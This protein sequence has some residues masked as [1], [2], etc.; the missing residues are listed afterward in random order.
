[1]HAF[2]QFALIGLGSGGIYAL[3]AQGIVLVYRGSGIVNFA[4]GGFAIVGAFCYYKLLRAHVPSGLAAPGAIGASG[5]LGLLTHAVLI[6]NI[7]QPSPLVRMVAT[8]GLLTALQAGA[9]LVFGSNTTF[10]ASPLPHGSV[11]VL[12][13]IITTHRLY[14]VAISGVLSVVLWAVYR[15]STFGLV[16]S[17]VSENIRSA[18]ALGRQPDAIA[19]INWGLG[20]ALAGAAGI[21]VAPIIGL[22]VGQL[23]LLLVPSLAAALVG[24][25]R[26]FWLTCIGGVAIGIAQSE[27]TYYVSAPGWSTSV[28][29]IVIAAVLVLRG[30]A[31]PVRGHVVDRLPLVGRGSISLSKIAIPAAMGVVAI[32]LLSDLWVL[33][34]TTSIIAAIICLS[35]VVVTGYTGQLS[36]AQ[37]VLAGCGALVAAWTSAKAGLPFLVD[38][39]IGTLAAVPLGLLVGLPSVR[40][41]GVS[42][43]IA[44]LGLGFA[45]A[46]IVLANPSYNGGDYGIAV[47]PPS[48]FGLGIDQ[49]TH[50]KR[51]GWFCLG[52]LLAVTLVVSNLR[53]SEIGRRL[54]AVR[55][56]ERAAASLG[57]A[58]VKTKLYAFAVSSALAGLG[59]VLIAFQSQY[60]QFGG[61]DVFAS[62]QVVVITVIGGLGFVAGALLAAV[63]APSGLAGYAL[64]RL[65]ASDQWLA[66]ATGTILVLSVLQQPNGLVVGL[67][68]A[69]DEVRRRLPRR[70]R[71]RRQLIAIPPLVSEAAEDRRS[72]RV[73]SVL[74]VEDVSVE[75][76]GVVALDRVT[77]RLSPGEILGMIGPNGAGKTTLIDAITGVAPI[78]TGRIALDD[79]DLAPLSSAARARAGIVRTFQSVELFNDLPVIDNLRVAAETPGLAAYLSE[80]LYP[81]T[82]QLSRLV[83]AAVHE[84]DVEGDLDRSPESLSYG[85]RRLVAIARALAADPSV[86][87][88]DEPSAG[89]DETERGELGH[90]L[91][92]LAKEW[93]IGIL[94]IEHD[95]DL[96]MSV[97]DQLAALDFGKIIASGTPTEVRHDPDVVAAYMGTEAS[98]A[99]ATP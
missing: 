91:R 59:G 99:H 72:S 32:A 17:A 1:M 63:A 61:F 40:T 96:V 98:A 44:T 34:L 9:T 23:S 53:R 28:P 54:I 43:G 12:G 13:T 52:C 22:S 94:L 83:S 36:L 87:L 37:Y 77:V 2:L 3:S 15:F 58:V 78:T 81:R 7:R 69:A 90:L 16:T 73:R 68:R 65:S 11:H 19:S 88:L 10:V 50:V 18:A 25:F 46:S 48:L 29:F 39:V 6:R 60:V 93:G 74:H 86:L 62:I 20:G 79:R 75:F 42:L 14:L 41:R 64:T 24:S 49:V 38:A 51:Y 67:V 92:R 33:A 56:N 80:L 21:L 89:L 27:L 82:K 4:H 30:Q 5:L 57:L 66:L 76:G 47:H 70:P 31:I 95:I 97:C 8:L 45:F 84:L 85:R 55:A 35:I 71:K 26:S